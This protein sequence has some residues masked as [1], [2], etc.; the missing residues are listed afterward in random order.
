[1]GSFYTQLLVHEADTG[2][3]A[4][5][6]AGLRRSSFVIPAT[7]GVSVICDRDIENQDLEAADSL[8]LTLS[9]RLRCAVVVLLNHDDDWLVFRYFDGGRFV[10]GLQV[11]HTGLSLRGSPARLRKLLS[12]DASLLELFLALVKPVVLQLDRHKALARILD[13][14]T[15]SVGIGYRYIRSDGLVQDLIKQGAIET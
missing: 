4:A 11:S 1:M 3:C 2:V 7:R 5:A 8:A 14:P 6:M 9:A 10:G 13:L 15:N 12:P